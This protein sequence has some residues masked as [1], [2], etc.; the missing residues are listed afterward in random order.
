MAEKEVKYAAEAPE[1]ALQAVIDARN[2]ERGSWQEQIE[3]L[4]DNGYAALKQRDDDIKLR[5]PKP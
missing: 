3:Y 5:N 1:R 4:I 2:K